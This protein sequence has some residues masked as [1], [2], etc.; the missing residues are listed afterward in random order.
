[1]PT[2]N[3]STILL[4]TFLI[5]TI[6]QFACAIYLPSMPAMRRAL[7]TD[8]EHIKLTYSWLLAAYGL[9]ML[10]YGPLSDSIGRKRVLIIGMAIYL[11][12]SV[13]TCVTNDLSILVFG[14]V[15]QGLGLGSATVAKAINKDTFAGGQFIKASAYISM[16]IAV[17][18]IVAQVLGGYIQHFFGW[19]G[20]F[21]FMFLY[22]FV[23]VAFAYWALPETNKNP[24]GNFSLKIIAKDYRHV[25]ASSLFV[26]LLLISTLTFS[27]EMIYNVTGPFLLQGVLGLSSVEYGWLSIFLVVGFMAGSYTTSYMATRTN[28]MTQL[29]S[30]QCIILIAVVTLLALSG[31]FNVYVILLP[32]MLFM[33]GNSMTLISSGSAGMMLFPDA[34]GTAGAVQGGVMLCTAGI[35]SSIAAE[36]PMHSQRPLG[37]MLLGFNLLTWVV[38]YFLVWRQRENICQT[39]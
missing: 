1:M 27:E 31:Q 16:G 3:K 15:I 21:V 14:R 2:Q 33:F 34:A 13:I 28:L 8:P 9:S 11:V 37:F 24:T 20:N 10:V 22:G 25:L 17:T 6:G 19:R 35:M 39:D 7:L 12:G 36:L 18:P 5:V 23:V 38:L 4:L 29:F 26:G 32:M 30:G